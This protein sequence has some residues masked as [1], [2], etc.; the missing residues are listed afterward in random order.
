MKMKREKHTKAKD[1]KVRKFFKSIVTPEGFEREER[2]PAVGGEYELWNEYSYPKLVI[3]S[4]TVQVE[5][6]VTFYQGK[7]EVTGTTNYKEGDGWYTFDRRGIENSF[8]MQE[9]LEG[10]QDPESDIRKG[11]Q[12]MLEAQIERAEKAIQR[13][14][15][16]LTVPH[17]GHRISEEKR[18]EIAK[19]LKAGKSHMFTP[20]GF[21]TAW[22]VS[23]RQNRWAERVPVEVAKFFGVETQLYKLAHDYD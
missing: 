6:L 15:G 22:E 1:V 13:L 23:T 14:T 12:A 11:G 5:F 4:D 21:G 7:M 9:G 8:Y 18:S 17:F 3:A 19:K 2:I 20:G 16:M 10:W